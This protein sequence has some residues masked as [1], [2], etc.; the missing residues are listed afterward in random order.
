MSVDAKINVTTIYNEDKLISVA[1]MS[2]FII[3]IVQYLILFSFGI[4][5][6]SIGN[7]IQFVSKVI[8]G[9]VYLRSLRIVIKRSIKI[10]FVTI[11][12]FSIILLINLALF[13]HNFSSI[14][15]VL[16][17]LVA[18]S[19][20]SMIYIYSIR[21][22]EVFKNVMFKSSRIVFVF[23][24]IISFLAIFHIID[25]GTYSMSLSYYMLLP[26]ITSFYSI[27]KYNIALDKFVLYLSLFVILFLGARWPFVCIIVYIVISFILSEKRFTY[28][29]LISLTIIITILVLSLINID[30]LIETLYLK[31]M[32]YGIQSRTLL[33]LMQQNISLSRRDLLYSIIFEKILENPIL[34]IGIAGD[35]LFIGGYTHNIF[36]EIVSGFGI[37]IGV[38]IIFYLFFISYKAIR[39]KNINYSE[40]SLMWFS[41]GFLPLIISGTYLTE[42]KF[43]IFLGIAF[44]NFQNN[45]KWRTNR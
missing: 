32:N 35:R 17:Q 42:F 40:M 39:S 10:F 30:I 7:R 27:I 4:E 44:R 38:P 11:V 20:P 41:L 8:V 15:G 21:D 37:V 24:I 14:K 6:T 34:G 9:G 19:I 23:G 25:I 36:L 12:L 16:F 26:A 31:L 45:S 5:G 13:P 28:K 18:M 1:I 22:L 2:P 29:K 3:L 33:L 43:W